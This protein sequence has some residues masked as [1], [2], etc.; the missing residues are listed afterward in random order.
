MVN[1][2][3]VS[4]FRSVV[5]VFLA[6][7]GG[8]AQSQ[9]RYDFER[10]FP[11]LQQPWYFSNLGGVAVGPQGF[12]YVI[13]EGSN[14]VLKF[15]E[16]GRL[17]DLWN[18]ASGASGSVATDSKGFVY[19]G[20]GNAI[21][22]YSSDGEFVVAFGAGGR[23]TIDD[24]DVVYL[25]SDAEIQRYLPPADG[26][27]TSPHTFDL[28]FGANGSD[29]GQFRGVGS[30]AT[31]RDGAIYITDAQ[32][33]L[34]HKF[35]ADGTFATRWGSPGSGPGQFDQFAPFSLQVSRD[36]EVHVADR[37][38]IQVFDMN[39]TYLR[40]I[41]VGQADFVGATYESFDFNANGDIIGNIE[42]GSVR[43]ITPQGGEVF[44]W[45]PANFGP[46]GF[47]TVLA[48]VQDSSGF[49]YVADACNILKYT[50]TFEFVLS[51]SPGCIEHLDIDANDRIYVS[52]GEGV[53][54]YGPPS[55]GLATDPPE[56]QDQWDLLTIVDRLLISANVGADQL[57]RLEND[58]RNPTE[59]GDLAADTFSSFGLALG[60]VNGD[61]APD[62]VAAVDGVNRLYL[63]TDGSNLGPGV[64]LGSA[65]DV[66][67]DGVLTDID[68]D[69]VLEYVS[70]NDGSV[71]RIY[72][73]DGVGG[74]TLRGGVSSDTE[75]TQVVLAADV[76]GINGIDL[77]FGNLGVNRLYLND[78]SGNFTE[79]A[80]FPGGSAQTYGAVAA[81][82]DNDNDLDLVLANNGVNEIL[83]NNGSGIFSVENLSDDNHDSRDV[84]VFDQSDDQ[85]VD[86]VV[87]NF[88]QLN[89]LYRNEGGTFFGEDVDDRVEPTTSVVTASKQGFPR[90]IFGNLGTPNVYYNDNLSGTDQEV[91]FGG[92]TSQTHDV[93]VAELGNLPPDAIRQGRQIRVGPS[94]MIY[95]ADDDGRVLRFQP[96]G[97]FL[98]ST[99]MINQPGGSVQRPF[100]LALD[101]NEN[102]YV[103]GLPNYL[104]TK[105]ASPTDLQSAQPHTFVQAFGSPDDSVV[106]RGLD[107][108]PAD[109]LL[110]S[111]NN[112]Q[113]A[114]YDTNFAPLGTLGER[115]FGPGFFD[116]AEN[117]DL[118][119]DGRLLVGEGGLSRLQVFTPG[120]TATDNARAI[121]VAGGGPYPGNALWDATQLNASFAY[122]VLVSQGFNADS[123]EYLSDN[124][125]L[126]L[127]GNGVA[128]VDGPATV[129][130]LQSAFT[131]FAAG[132]G[133][134]TV[135]LVDHGGFDT[136]RISGTEVMPASSLAGL[137]NA[138]QSAHPGAPL[139][140]IY[141][142]CQSGSF[143]DDLQSAGDERVVIASSEADENAY[144]VSQGTLSFSN[145]FW[146]HIFNGLSLGQSFSLARSSQQA[147]FVNQS[148]LLDAD[149]DG[150]FNSATDLAVVANRFIGNGVVQNAN[151]PQINGVSDPQTISDGSIATLTA[152]DVTDPDGIARV[153][154][155]LRP[156]GFNPAAADT[157][158]QGLPIVDLNRVG[159]SDTFEATSDSF[160]AEGSYQVTVYA[161]DAIGNRAVPQV[162]SVTVN[163]PLRRRAIIVT[164]GSTQLQQRSRNA[165][166]AFA[167]LAEQGYGAA[168]ESCSG[169]ISLCDNACDN[170]CYL[171]NDGVAGVDT[172][173]TI[174]NL[175]DAITNWGT[176]D[177]QD[178]TLYLVAPRTANGFE[179]SDTEVLTAPALK[180]LLDTA[181]QTNDGRV[182]VVIEGDNARPF[183]QELTAV[184]GQS[185]ILI[186]STDTD[187]QATFLRAGQVTFSKFF[188][189]QVLNGASVGQAFR[190]AR[191]AI[192]FRQGSQQP[193]L[194]DS[195]NG[196]P[197][198]FADG[199]V[200][201]NYAIGS[202]VLLAGDDPIIASL[203]VSDELTGDFE[204]ITA[205][206]TSTGT[207]NEVVAVVTRPNGQVISQSLT[208]VPGGAFS[209]PSYGLC[210]SAGEYQV[211][212]Y[213]SD[214]EDNTSLPE[215]TVVNRASDC[216]EFLFLNG[217]E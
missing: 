38:R 170:I 50:N 32:L 180:S 195:G 168:E 176:D 144:F 91:E 68:A 65:T 36:N 77:F 95:L 89:R 177:T 120:V 85:T 76:D 96:D 27:D 159:D 19:V 211:A 97:T 190:F 148:P 117:I 73:N 128:D 140:I 59:L 55:S 191:S 104:V 198:E 157:P 173:P 201:R 208:P 125:D 72:E 204:A 69:S 58:L 11:V 175:S 192:R 129:A 194:D 8:L 109:E 165:G 80:T 41:P 67:R 24:L 210:G 118:A 162:T 61:F 141:D 213:A 126:D 21:E 12:V 182:T 147:T 103:T 81:D 30:I 99:P 14:R 111:E 101:S 90:V 113:F 92:A 48:V 13:D 212:V 64:N 47:R 137:V 86:V 9:T 130:N 88:N 142:A 60:D 71:N 164:G 136:F 18:P 57:T 127:S 181:Q 122:R 186:A 199:L 4:R 53:L 149:G 115:G 155:V 202:G 183:M 56:I 145:Q 154:A 3:A 74:F 16:A 51:F 189:N 2:S 112:I 75:A 206:V 52:T 160:I 93:L 35:L 62:L 43:K 196:V 139:N 100:R 119:P 163:N 133:A 179:L 200:A 193:Q 207:V 105:Y 54:V 205:E 26:L 39:G 23:A 169:S 121:I 20:T 161:E 116:G 203:S 44:Q 6:L 185:R 83:R 106:R 10:V 28:S 15:N 216:D 158:V 110:I 197:N 152:I 114:I 166:R 146:T 215:T 63:N 78:G 82:L 123:I 188:W 132:A 7:L 143:M 70:A 150:S 172:S 102:L 45:T 135:Y 107:V 131:N 66:T 31:D 134:L 174:D 151:A 187:E 22:K 184:A 37:G 178:L 33:G 217:F 138:W 1:T 156:P 25:A 171:S 167:A 87:A 17:V 49:Y 108:N 5:L 214:T 209:S 29:P 94:G 40:E 98:A 84:A 42:F 153:W 79:L 46:G 34:V 124:V